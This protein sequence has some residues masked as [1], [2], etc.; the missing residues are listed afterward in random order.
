MA[1][2]IAASWRAREDTA[3]SEGQACLASN[4]KTDFAG[5]CHR[6]L[7]CKSARQ[8]LGFAEAEASRH[9]GNACIHQQ[10]GMDKGLA[11]ARHLCCDASK[12]EVCDAMC[13]QPGVQLCVVEGALAWLVQ[14]LLTLQMPWYIVSSPACR[15]L[16]MLLRLRSLINMLLQLIHACTE[17]EPGQVCVAAVK[18]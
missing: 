1:M 5:H 15:P 7:C 11:K 14:Q 8:L 18:I 2:A 16:I 9:F 6:V 17:H 3:L 4:E 13:L 12:Q 10:Q